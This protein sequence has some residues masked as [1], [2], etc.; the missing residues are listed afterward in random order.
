MSDV[1]RQMM[2]YDAQKKSLVVAFLLWF[3]LGYL[4]AHRFYAGKTLSGILQLVMSLIGAA[5]TFAGVGF[6]LLGVVGI[7]LFV[8]IFLLPGLIRNHNVALVSRLS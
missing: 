5:L 4:G 8:D 2:M 6:V 7:W 1:S 3:F